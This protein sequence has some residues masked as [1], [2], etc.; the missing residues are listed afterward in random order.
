MADRGIN[1]GPNEANS[2]QSSSGDDGLPVIGLNHYAVRREAPAIEER[3]VMIR[4]P[5]IGCEVWIVS[6]L[7]VPFDPRPV[8]RPGVNSLTRDVGHEQT[9]YSADCRSGS[10][11]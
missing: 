10:G 8:G 7:L 4:D 3:T 6:P 9:I 2:A 5:S 11:S 1:D